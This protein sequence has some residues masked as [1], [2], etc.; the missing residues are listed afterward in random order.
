MRHK[1]NVFYS[2]KVSQKIILLRFILLGLPS[3]KMKLNKSNGGNGYQKFHLIDNMVFFR[4][5]K[6]Y[7]R[8]M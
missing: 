3:A 5:R 4:W 6:M 8:I 1:N 7:V 2:R